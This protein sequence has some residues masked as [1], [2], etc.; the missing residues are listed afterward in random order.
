MTRARVDFSH[1]DTLSPESRHRLSRR[2]FSQRRPPLSRIGFRL[3]IGTDSAHM[4]LT[5]QRILT[6]LGR[7]AFE[8]GENSDTL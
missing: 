7:M 1:Q 6:A 5:G 2:A 4:S 3:Q 8:S